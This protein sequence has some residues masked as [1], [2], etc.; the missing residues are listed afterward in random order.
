NIVDLSGIQHTAKNLMQAVE[1]SAS[2]FELS[3]SKVSNILTDSPSVM[4]KMQHDLVVKHPHLISTP[5]YLHW[6]GNLICDIITYPVANKL[7]KQNNELAHFF[8]G[9]HFWGHE[10]CVWQKAASI[11]CW[12]RTNVETR[13]YSIG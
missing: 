10:L 6:P 2:T 3:M 11:S 1:T 5:C 8:N 13:W 4:L 12:F 9:S 7:I